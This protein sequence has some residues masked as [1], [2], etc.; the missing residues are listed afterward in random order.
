MS[1]RGDQRTDHD[2]KRKKLKSSTK[3]EEDEFRQYA[4][5]VIGAP[6]V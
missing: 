6:L 2:D 5:G 1:N 4:Y 3:K